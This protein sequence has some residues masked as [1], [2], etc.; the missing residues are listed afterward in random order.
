MPT[1][2]TADGAL[3]HYT[4]WGG[5]APVVFIHGWSLDAGMWDYQVVALAEAGLRPITYDRRGHGRSEASPGGYDYDTL[6]DDLAALLAH[7]DLRGVTLVA[8][9]MGGGEII[10]LCARYGVGRIAR[11][12]FL[13]ATAPFARRTADNPSGIPGEVFTATAAALR[14]DRAGW[15]AAGAP[16]YFAQDQPARCPSQATVEEGVRMCL[17]TPLPVQLACLESTTTRD[18]RPDLPAVTIPTLVIHGDADASAPL[19]ATGQRLVAGIA[20]SELRVYAGAPHGLYITDS[21]RLNADLL[22]FIDA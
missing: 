10:R 9:S 16:A 7:L 21:E 11:A 8:H 12:V 3:L 14:R 4:D 19:V 2:V 20:G 13:S 22:A 18:L 6:A 17:G 15:F 5:G 1:F